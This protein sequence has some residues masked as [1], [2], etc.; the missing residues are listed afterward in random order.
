MRCAEGTVDSL[1]SVFLAHHGSQSSDGADIL[2][3][4]LGELDRAARAAWPELALAPERFISYLAARISTEASDLTLALKE[5]HA[6]DLFLACACNEGIPG[7]VEAFRAHTR[8]AVE[9]FVRGVDPSPPAIDE[10]MQA[11]FE[12]LL[13]PHDG[14]PARLTSYAGRG[15]LA[16]WVGVA[17]QRMALSLRRGESAQAR[18]RERAAMADLSIA[19]D[20]ELAYLKQRYRKEYEAAFANA[21]ALLSVRERAILRLHLSGGLTLEALG[22]IYRVNASTVCRW[23]A[24]A[25]TRLAAETEKDLRQRLRLSATELHSLTRLVITQLDFSVGRI[26]QE[27][28]PRH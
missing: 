17:A 25:Q 22:A 19:G 2:S 12:K 15:P 3:G 21:A 28:P 27:K 11:L 18:A 9:T 7:A 1:A 24:T 10:V 4:Q 8:A 26:L 5:I 20:A 13:V 14:E 16:G 6:G 23:I